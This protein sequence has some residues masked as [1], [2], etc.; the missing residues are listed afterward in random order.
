MLID[1]VHPRLLNVYDSSKLIGELNCKGKGCISN[2]II[3]EVRL[4]FVVGIVGNCNSK[5]LKRLVE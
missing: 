4:H 2:L 3:K 5:I 1:R